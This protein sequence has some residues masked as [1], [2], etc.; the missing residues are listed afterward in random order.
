MPL[1]TEGTRRLRVP[2]AALL[3]V[4]GSA[5]PGGAQV[6]AVGTDTAVIAADPGDVRGSARSA[7]ARFE[8]ARER[9]LPLTFASYG[10][11]CDEVVGRLCTW[12]GEGEWRP[13]PD[14]EE[15][16]RLRDELLAELDSLQGSSPGDDWIAGQRVWYRAEGGD[17]DAALATAR[18]CGAESWWCDALEG[19]ALHGLGRHTD[20]EAAF[21]RALRGMDEEKA[22]EWR[23]LERV[24]G[25][26]T[27]DW[28]RDLE[29]AGPDSLEAGLEW[30]WRLADPLYLV[31]GNDRLTAHYARW[32]V[33]TLKDGARNPFRMSWGDDLEE[34]T[35]RTGWEL[36]WERSPS[37]ALGGPFT[38]TGHKHPEARE[39]MASEKALTAPTTVAAEEFPA[40]RRRPRSL[41]APPYAPILLP[42][43]AELAVFP[44]MDRTLVVA[45]AFLP[46]DTTYHASHDHERPWLEPREQAGMPDR[47]GLF[48][49]PV[50]G[51][52]PIERRQDGSTDGAL[53]LELPAGGYV[54]SVESW[55]PAQRRAGRLRRGLE[56]RPAPP[57][58]AV[59]S[60]LLLLDGD[61]P[62]PVSLEE[63][64]PAAL[65]RA[66]IGSGQRLAIAWEIAGLGF[67]PETLQLELSVAGTDRNVFRRLGEFLGLAERPPS[68]ALSWEEPAPNAPTHQFRHLHLDLPPLDPGTYQITLTLRTQGRS[69]AVTRKAFE[70][71]EP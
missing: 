71:V 63:A 13:T 22:R 48:A 64:L 40:D 9:H 39:W 16:R 6:G 35:V 51:G 55:S 23:L 5:M 47:V 38:V 62:A 67:R 53:L 18:A 15:V 52:H 27:R 31:E 3:C 4:T 7:Q 57:D 24:V 65:P 32:T 41:Y 14:P 36:G 20:A 12:F 42:M 33:A 34:L 61:R 56:A 54:V 58:V 49:L 1:V 2:L 46:E 43:E 8:R 59:L 30:L 29:R 70:V 44:R 37:R 17:W 10:G 69:D 21:G 19:L 68:L 50:D 25:R 11:D 60:D 66:R 45:T 28:L 26:S